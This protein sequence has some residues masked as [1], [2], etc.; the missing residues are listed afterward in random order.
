MDH[1]ANG[2][3]VLIAMPSAVYGPDDPSEIGNLI[4]QARTG[5]LKL[6]MFPDT[7]FDFVYVE[8]LADGIIAVHDRGRIGES[9]NLPGDRGTLGDLMD[10]T[11]QLSGRKPPRAPMPPRADPH[12][13]RRHR[14]DVWGQG[15][16]RAGVRAAPPGG[17]AARN[18][19][20]HGS[21]QRLATASRR[22]G[23]TGS[24]SGRRYSAGR[25][26]ARSRSRVPARALWARRP[27]RR[28]RGASG[29][30]RG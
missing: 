28:R 19:A 21:V 26:P 27:Q 8:D 14:L 18:A 24:H 5:K 25:G 13:R 4:D 11:S 29:G 6:R 20:P 23:A 2:A 3:P 7:G 10:K 9:Y 15:A 17:G 1:I 16:P 22:G 12:L 30:A